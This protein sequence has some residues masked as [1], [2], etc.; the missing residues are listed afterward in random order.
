[1]LTAFALSAAYAG[2]AGGLFAILV[3]FIDPNEF[4]IAASL[5]HLTYI[6][7]GGLGSIGGSSSV[8]T[9]VRIA[10]ALLRPIK[11][12]TDFAAALVLLAALLFMPMA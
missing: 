7:V 9:A 10:R 4:G 5:R 2:L 8:R 3:G 12:Y 1:M 6:V 11:E